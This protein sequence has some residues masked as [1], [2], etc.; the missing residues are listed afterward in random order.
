MCRSMVMGRMRRKAQKASTWTIHMAWCQPS[1]VLSLAPSTRVA[2]GYPT[3]L[4]RSNEGDPH[5]AMRNISVS[6]AGEPDHQ[7]HAEDDGVLGLGLDA[8]A[9]RALDVA[10]ADGPGDAGQE[11]EAG[12]V[13]HE[14]ER[15][16]RR[17]VQELEALGDLVVDLEG[18]GDG[19]QHEEAEVDEGVHEAGR[20]VPQQRPHVDAGP[21]VLQAAAGVAARRG[22]AVG[23]APL[24]VP[25]PEGEE[26][27]DVHEQDRD[28]RVER[29]DERVRHPAEHLAGDRADVVP[30]GPQREDARQQGEEAG[31]DPE[32]EDELVGPQPPGPGGGGR[33]LGRRGGDG[34]AHGRR[35]PTCRRTA[36]AGEPSAAR[37]RPAEPRELSRRSGGPG[38]GCA[39]PGRP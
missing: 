10:A 20:G 17:A 30:A 26:V 19:Q 11:H 3:K 21:V 9:V 15:L 28:H 2:S 38:R 27:R 7:E 37:D 16:V 31:E 36:Q 5:E 18:R 35:E 13:A 34:R 6:V 4:H 22:P 12:G 29:D 24:P 32:A 33:R 8:D 14:G 25:H 23:R 39:R 1:S